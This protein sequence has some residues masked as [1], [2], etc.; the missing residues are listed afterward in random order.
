MYVLAHL[1]TCAHTHANTHTQ[2][3]KSVRKH[4]AQVGGGI[5]PGLLFLTRKEPMNLEPHWQKQAEGL[6]TG[7]HV[8]VTPKAQDNSHGSREE[9]THGNPSRTNCPPIEW[10][11]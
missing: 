5:Y 6:L 10:P 2:V 3:L 7:K 1:Y 9:N 4:K 8:S 11:G